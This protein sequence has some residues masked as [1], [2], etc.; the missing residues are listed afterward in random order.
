MKKIA[1]SLF[2]LCLVLLCIEFFGFLTYFTVFHEFYSKK[3]VKKMLN[4]NLKV[5]VDTN[6]TKAGDLWVGSQVEILHPYFGYLRDPERNKGISDQ[7]FPSFQKKQLSKK[8]FDQITIG[9][10]GGSFAKE[11]FFLGIDHL[12][13]CFFNTYKKVNIINFSIGGYK[14]P[15]QLMVLNYLL[16]TGA[17]F[18]IVIN[19]DG[20][21]EVALPYVENV[22]NGVSPFYPRNWLYRAKSLNDPVEI[23][24]IGKIHFIRGLKRSGA[25]AVKKHKLYRSPT[26]TLIWRLIDNALSSRIALTRARLQ[27]LGRQGLGFAVKGPEYRSSSSAAMFDDLTDLWMRCSL[28][29][30]Y[31]CKSYNIKYYHFL[32][33]NQY[34]PDSKPLSFK[35]KKNAF[36]PKHPY[37][38]GVLNG[39]PKLRKKG[40]L[41]IQN[42]VNFLDLTDVFK[43][44]PETLYKDTCCHLNER[45]YQLIIEKICGFIM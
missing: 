24:L 34:D 22:K 23:A 33:P 37:R 1:L 40:A 39:Y 13:E 7:G 32:Q 35:E 11:T 4:Q 16:S 29:M 19:I 36:D 5:H 15:Q 45:G 9:I 30:H 18:D 28:S 14:Q 31:L 17:Q 26:L 38:D 21:N 6:I 8:K 42:N 3:Q 12:K 44:Q 2:A 43:D 25:L 41:L 27:E 20:F 10:F